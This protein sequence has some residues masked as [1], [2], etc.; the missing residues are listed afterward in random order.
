MPD[1]SRLVTIPSLDDSALA[2]RGCSTLYVL[3]PVPN[4]NGMINWSTE[5]QLLRD[6]MHTFLMTH[7]YPGEVITEHL[8]TPLDW[9][10]QGMAAGTPF[11]PSA[12]PDPSVH[13]TSS[14][15]SPECSSPGRER[16]RESASPWCSS[17]ANSR[18][19]E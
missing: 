13:R 17:P 15:D 4:L 19:T 1:P 6:R 11:V 12:R 7:G 10:A 9:Q 16:C 5:A 18:P 14:A 3:E 8:V 2:P